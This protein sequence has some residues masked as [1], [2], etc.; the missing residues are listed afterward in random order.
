[1]NG[2]DVFVHSHAAQQ[3]ATLAELNAVIA[4][5]RPLVEGASR[6][7]LGEGPQ[8]AAIA[9]VGEQPGDREEIEGRPFVGPAGQVLDRALGEAGIDRRQSYVTRVRMRRAVQSA[10]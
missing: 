8:G 4:A 5:S 2:S 6:A 10:A 7:V 9:F 1:M 3:P